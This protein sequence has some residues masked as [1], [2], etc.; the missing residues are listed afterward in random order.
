MSAKDAKQ[1]VRRL[2]RAG[3]LVE[4]TGNLH[5]VV[6]DERGSRLTTFPSTPSDHRSLRNARSELR[7]GGVSGI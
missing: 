6:W 5:Y 1:L 2:R 4:L 3:L 7:R